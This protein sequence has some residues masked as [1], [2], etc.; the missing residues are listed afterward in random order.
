MPNITSADI[1]RRAPEGAAIDFDGSTEYVRSAAADF[2]VADSWTIECWLNVDALTTGYVFDCTE[3]AGGNRIALFLDAT[4]GNRLK[5]RV[6]SSAAVST[7]LRSQPCRV[8]ETYCATLVKSGASFSF[9]VNGV[10][11]DSNAGA[12]TLAASTARTLTVG[13]T[14]A[15]ATFFNGFVRSLALWNTARSATSI[16]RTFNGGFV[17]LNLLR[18]TLADYAEAGNLRHWWR[19][20]RP[21]GS[22]GVGG[23]VVNDHVIVGGVSLEAVSAGV[24][25]ADYAIAG[26]A[27][28]GGNLWN[29]ASVRLVRNAS[30]PQQLVNLPGAA[31]GVSGTFTVSVWV[32]AT[33]PT[34]GTDPQTFFQI[35]TAGSLANSVH[36]IQNGTLAG[37][38][39][40]VLVYDSGGVQIYTARW[41]GALAASAW[42]H[43]ALTYSGTGTALGYV[44]GVLTAPNSTPI[45]IAGAMTDTSR[46]VSIGANVSAGRPFDGDVG[47]VC[48]WNS[49]L[50]S[51]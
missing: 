38:P 36:M 1:Q 33:D 11:H 43:V 14:G 7:T 28:G 37:D 46:G 6:W 9:Y 5:A 34:F 30:L 44:N 49:V 2:S 26:S 51:S 19:F 31:I 41:N 4:D 10:L 40:E 8:G 23:A 18:S 27:V 12:V 25:T 20:A 50:T 45:D 21:S 16:R 3:P 42:A 13:A 39:W 48:V 17:Q 24:G 29:G 47:P 22:F 35:N 32:R 15:G